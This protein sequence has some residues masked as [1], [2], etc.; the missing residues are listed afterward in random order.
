M[1]NLQLIRINWM[2]ILLFT[3]H[4]MLLKSIMKE[5]FIL[6]LQLKF[7]HLQFD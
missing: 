5:L 6:K 7:V 3:I 4:E 2:V 1:V